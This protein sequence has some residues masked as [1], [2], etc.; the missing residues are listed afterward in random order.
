MELFLFSKKNNRKELHVLVAGQP[1]VKL[2]LTLDF[3]VC[4]ALNGFFFFLSLKYFKVEFSMHKVKVTF[5]FLKF[6][7]QIQLSS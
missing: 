5:N 6:H 4:N 1:V 3:S 7:P 2:L